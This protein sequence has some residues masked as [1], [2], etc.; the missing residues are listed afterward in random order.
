MGMT[1]KRSKDSK[2]PRV[3]AHKVA[4]IRGGV[5]VKASEL[6]GEFLLEGTPLSAP[7][8]GICNVV[9]YATVSAAALAAATTIKVKK[10]H[11]FV[12]NDIVLV[13]EN[14]VAV[15]ITAIDKTNSG[16]DEITVNAALGALAIGDAIILAAAEADS[17]DKDSA[18]KYIPQSIAGTNKPVDVKDNLDVDAWLIAVTQGNDLPELLASKLKGIINY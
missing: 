12:I 7:T 5:S 17:T 15:K 1:V 16:Y 9:K 3:L 11:H 8:N 18:L 13:K 6:G 2:L 10:G 4:D 14:D